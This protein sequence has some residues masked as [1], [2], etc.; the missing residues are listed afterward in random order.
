MKH[1]MSIDPLTDYRP[2]WHPRAQVAFIVGLMGMLW[3]V[4][5][6]P[7]DAHTAISVALDSNIL[8]DR[9][10]VIFAQGTGSLTV[11]DLETGEVLL[12]KKPEKDFSYSGK[13]E[14][15]ANGVLM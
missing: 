10:R 14:P 6:G 4:G 15:S 1:F 9:G 5:A 3:L 13:F 2:T 7:V 12:R 11:L 8:V